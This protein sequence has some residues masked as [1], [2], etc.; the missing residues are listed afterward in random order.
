MTAAVVWL[1]QRGKEDMGSAE[2]L[3]HLPGKK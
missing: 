1:Q 2:W 3:G